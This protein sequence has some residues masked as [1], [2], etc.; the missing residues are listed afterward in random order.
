MAKV[1]SVQMDQQS[2]TATQGQA[3]QHTVLID[4]P[5]TKEGTDLGMMG[6]EMLLVALG[7]CFMSNLLEIVRTRE[8]AVSN[9]HVDVLGTMGTAPSRF[10]A[11][12]LQI[13]AVFEDQATMEK[14]VTMAERACLVAN[15]LR[16][17]MDVTFSVR[18]SE[19][20]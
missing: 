18:A 17:A 6:G 19:T 5:E 13:S 20:T 8:A 16:P 15:T 9:I 11:V 12:E 3:R 2:L 7:G 10:E 4:R 14:Y 1:I